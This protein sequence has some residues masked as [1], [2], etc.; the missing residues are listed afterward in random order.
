MNRLNRKLIYSIHEYSK[1]DQ[2]ETPTNPKGGANAE[3]IL[4]KRGEEPFR[5][6]PSERVRKTNMIAK[7]ATRTFEDECQGQQWYKERTFNETQ[8]LGNENNR[9]ENIGV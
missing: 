7:E 4:Q 2:Y 5:E 8:D 9:G 6:Y 1:G 3:K